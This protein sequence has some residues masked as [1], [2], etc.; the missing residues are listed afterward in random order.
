[1][2]WLA[3]PAPRAACDQQ[4]NNRHRDRPLPAEETA[5]CDNHANTPAD[6]GQR[7]VFRHVTKWTNDFEDQ[8]QP[9][10]D[11][12]AVSSALPAQPLKPCVALGLPPK[13]KAVEY[14]WRWTRFD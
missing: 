7:P 3:I 4:P 6:H 2:D 11:P 14:G 1:L 10:S 9:G 13:S 12:S 8:K 5:N